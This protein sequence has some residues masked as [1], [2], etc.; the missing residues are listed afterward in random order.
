MAEARE[1]RAIFFDAAGTLFESREPV[2]HAYSRIAREHGL[3]ASVDAVTAGFRHAFGSAP[4]LA[5]GPGHDSSR[6]RHLERG[7]WR[8]RVRES[9]AGL[10]EFRDFDAYFDDL[11]AYFADPAHWQVD[12]EAVTTLDRLKSSG[13]R[14]GVIS[15]FD[16]RVYRILDG[17]G[18]TGYFDSITISSEA[19]YAKPR[20]EIF[21]LALR[22]LGVEARD[23]MHVGDSPHLDLAAASEAGMV[24]ALIDPALKG[25]PAIEGRTARVRSLASAIG[26]AHIFGFA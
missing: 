25:A 6:L 18:L 20:R 26:V 15:N 21:D 12:P 17:L 8:E 14:L 5:F 4:G 7:W 19:G 23:A 9:F 3:D 22:S 24:A 1:R 13:L 2:G 11:F 16:H 10:G